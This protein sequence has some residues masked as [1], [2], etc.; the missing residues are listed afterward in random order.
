MKLRSIVA[1]VVLLASAAV[2]RGDGP[3]DNLPDNVRQIPP[4]GI[5]VSEADA[6]EL[7]R[8]LD[9][10]GDLIKQLHKPGKSPS[11]TARRQRYLPDVEIFYRASRD[12][13]RHKEFFKANEVQ[14]AIKQV[15]TGLER[16]R[17]LLKGEAPW[18]RQTGLVVRGYRSRIDGSAQ[19][20]GL[21]IPESYG[22]AGGAPF[23]L[24]I[25]C[26]GRGEVLSEVNFINQRMRQV[27]QIHPADTIV[28]HPYGRYCNAFKFAGEVD[29]LEA[30]ESVQRDYRID[31]DKIMMRGFSMGGA[32]CWQFAVH[33]AD[34]WAAAT[35]GAGFAE[36]AEFLRVFQNEKVRPTWYEQKLWHWYDCTDYAVNLSQCPTI[37]YSGEFD[38]QKQAADIM[39]KALAREEIDL[40]HLIG[41]KMKHAYHPE[42][43]AQIERM[44]VDIAA[45]GRERFPRT[46]RFSTYTLKYNRA[47]WVTVDGLKE[48]WSEARIQ[49]EAAPEGTVTARTSNISDLTFSY[50]AGWAS[51]DITKPVQVVIDGQNVAGP[52]P[53]SDRSWECRLF[54]SD[55]KWQLGARPAKADVVRKRHD[56]QGPI[57]DAFMNSFVFVRPTGKS[58]NP[59]FA[60][61]CEAEMQHAITHWRQQFRGDARVIDDTQVDKTV[62]EKSH[63]VLW[64]DADSNAVLRKIAE[65]L[66]IGWK[67]DQIVAGDR[68]YPSAD[69]AL[70]LIAPNPLNPQ[71]YVVLNSGFTYREYDYLNNARQVP[72][73][74][75]W[76]VV[77]L[78]T[79]PNSRYPGKVVAADFFDEEWKLRPPHQKASKPSN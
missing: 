7:T 58:A 35:P 50:P 77:D 46:I 37:A 8:L 48:H 33:F 17:A 63:L 73:L 43:L 5:E 10:L 38:S 39:E 14:T 78:R 70:L 59:A 25:W 53:G 9:E 67:N 12:A 71:R 44:L 40:V 26:H 52:K 15:G 23:R 47:G 64:G 36:T 62:I 16:A 74:P 42:S 2:L 79:P 69:H 31:E 56:L 54:H 75:D 4:R 20:Y 60:K 11:E 32:A 57:D 13:L 29:V 61:W 28:L 30:L 45:K 24:D 68:K 51:F 55:G 3:K 72:K 34:R 66:P 41:P 76:A 1:A 6:T 21:V 65:D 27:G 49:A 18:L 19:P 22:T